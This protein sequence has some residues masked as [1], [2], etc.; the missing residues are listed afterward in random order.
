MCSG[1]WRVE[2]AGT[3]NRMQKRMRIW[4]VQQSAKTAGMKTGCK[5]ECGF[6]MCSRVPKQQ[7]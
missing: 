5:R 2:I 6:G 3:E 1:G 7:E 4:N